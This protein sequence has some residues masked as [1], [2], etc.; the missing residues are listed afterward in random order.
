M[1]KGRCQMHLT[2][3]FQAH[4]VDTPFKIHSCKLASLKVYRLIQSSCIGS[5]GI[6]T[7]T[8]VV[9]HAAMIAAAAELHRQQ[10]LLFRMQAWELEAFL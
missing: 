3:A 2:A 7:H 8:S 1:V 9:T 4:D 10:L 5:S 6:K